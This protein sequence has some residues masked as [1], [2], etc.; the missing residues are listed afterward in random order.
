MNKKQIKQLVTEAN[1]VFANV[2]H[3]VKTLTE[4][5]PLVLFTKEQAEE[6]QDSVFDMPYGYY[7]NKYEYYLQGA[8]QKVEG[9]D[10]T[11][12]LT[13][14]DWGDTISVCVDDLPFS[15]QI[16][17]LERLEERAEA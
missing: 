8:V 3:A 14:E 17:L 7:V 15:S 12:F 5:N 11:L 4:K 13:G 10:V 6:D 9:N 1:K 16:E 2:A